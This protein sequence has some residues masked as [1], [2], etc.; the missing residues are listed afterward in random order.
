MN[1][2][3]EIFAVFLENN[4]FLKKLFFQFPPKLQIFFRR[5]HL[6]HCISQYNCVK[7]ILHYN[8]I[9]LGVQLT[10]FKVRR[11]GIGNLQLVLALLSLSRFFAVVLSFSYLKL[12]LKKK[13]YMY[14]FCVHSY[15]FCRTLTYIVEHHFVYVRI[16]S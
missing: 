6:H 1:G 12:Q 15:V 2:R 16:F 8:P 9:N 3:K 4:I 7:Q 11:C 13:F 14:N 10:T 5:S